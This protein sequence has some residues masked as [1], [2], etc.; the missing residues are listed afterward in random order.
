MNP[1]YVE[2]CEPLQVV[3]ERGAVIARAI[4]I[5]CGAK[6]E[7]R[8]AK[9]PETELVKRHYI[10]RGWSL[11]KGCICPSCQSQKKEPKPMATVTKIEPKPTVS[12]AAN[13]DAARKNKRLVIVTLEDCYNES[14]RRYND[15]H[16]DATVAKELDLAPGFVA[17]VREEFYGKMAEP[18]EITELR[19]KL[20]ELTAATAATADLSAE[21]DKLATKNGW[22]T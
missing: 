8:M 18:T 7:W 6:D 4:C 10:V 2:A 16:S 19:G 9:P 1:K 3:T 11:K 17:L 13:S 14:K 15:G 21:L 20:A 22:R 12:L 5:Q